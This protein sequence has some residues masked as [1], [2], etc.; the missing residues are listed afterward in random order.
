AA[1]S[2]AGCS[3][4]SVF[5]SG[6]VTGWVCTGAGS[7]VSAAGGAAGGW[8]AGEA[9]SGRRFAALF[10]VTDVA[11]AGVELRPTTYPIVKNTPNKITTM[12]NALSSCRF[13]STSSY[14]PSVL[15]IR[16]V[17]AALTAYVFAAGLEPSPAA[18]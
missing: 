10:G 9:A 3:R 7:L 8:A 13:P 18:T 1:T 16:M 17:D 14:S 2:R 5:F 6:G 12:K 4:G 15:L 11:E